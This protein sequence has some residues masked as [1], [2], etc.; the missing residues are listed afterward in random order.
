MRGPIDGG[1]HMVKMQG[2][3][4]GVGGLLKIYE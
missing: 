1:I 4:G 3:Q 2:L